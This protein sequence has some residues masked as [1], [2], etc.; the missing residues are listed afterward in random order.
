MPLV[1]SKEILLAAL[2]QRFAVGAFNAN[3]MEQVQAIVEVA[4]EE[5]AP[6]IVQVSQGAIRYAGLEFAA[7]MVKIAADLV[8]VPVVL[9]LDHGS[10]FEQNIRC[11][12]A[13]FTSLMFDGSEL[14]Y[15][16]N[17]AIT[18]RVCEI[19]HA[20]GIPVEAELGRVLQFAPG[21]TEEEVKRAMTDPE[22]AGE[23]V[24]RTGA[25]SLA[26]AVGSVHAMRERRARLD[27]ERIAAI[28][29]RANLPLVLHGSSGVKE[30]DLKEAIQSGIC[31]INVATYLN[32]AFTRGLKDGLA[33]HPDEVDPR[34]FLAISREYVKEA[35]R[36]KIRLFGSAGRAGV[37]GGLR[38]G[39]ARHPGTQLEKDESK[40]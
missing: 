16:E 17:V 27:I 1:R 19:A 24:A 34:K 21:V 9:H 33:K 20:V 31:K 11:L 30:E 8:D 12:R 10:S 4:Q 39:S 32:Q 29:R 15:E 35:V 5:R 13:G 6:V 7:G 25:D 3:N 28:R 22:Q 40:E 14:P 26:V 38:P 2:E 23:F 18:K 37:G 36:E